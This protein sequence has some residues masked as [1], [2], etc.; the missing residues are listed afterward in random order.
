MY[1]LGPLQGLKI[2]VFK[3]KHDQVFSIH[4]LL[5]WHKNL[6]FLKLALLRS[7]SMKRNY[8]GLIFTYYLL[9]TSL[10]PMTLRVRNDD[11]PIMLT[12]GT[13]LTLTTFDYALMTL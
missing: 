2:R 9:Q 10:T 11:A 12:L 5:N 3:A 7:V 4:T 1:I 6:N 8:R 13:S